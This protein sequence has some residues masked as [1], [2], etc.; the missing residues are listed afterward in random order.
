[1]YMPR[2]LAFCDVLQCVAVSCS[3]LQW[4]GQEVC[5]RVQKRY[6]YSC[7]LWSGYD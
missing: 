3:E 5:V 7:T 4:V 2:L 6:E 1:M